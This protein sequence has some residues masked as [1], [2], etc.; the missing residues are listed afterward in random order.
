MNDTTIIK[1]ISN[2]HSAIIDLLIFIFVTLFTIYFTLHI[3]LKLDTFILPGLKIE[4]LYIKWDEKISVKIDSIKITKSNTKNNFDI[5]KVDLKKL[6]RETHVLDTVFSE[7][8]INTIQYNDINATFS[9]KEHHNGYLKIY[10]PRLRAHITIDMNAHLLQFSIK[11]FQD[12]STHSTITGKLLGDTLEHR[13][14]GAL[15][16]NVADTI[17]LDLFLL[18]DR[19]KLSI[20]AKGSQ[21]IT[22]P[23]GPAVE[24]A[25][26]GPLINPWII[27]QLQGES[28]SIDYLKAT[29]E[30]DNPITLLDTLDVKACY[31]GV[32]YVFAPGYAPAIAEK[33][34]LAFKDRIL[35][36]YPRKGTFYGQPGGTT[37]V[38]IDFKTPENPLLTVDVDTT[39]RLSKKLIS[40]LKG[41][42]ITL[43]FY[44]KSG[45]TKVK[46]ALWI[47][48]RDIEISANGGFSSQKGLFNFSDTDIHVKDVKVNL[49]NTDVDIY[50]LNASLLDD[51][52]NVDLSG[53]F[54]PIKEIGRFDI[55]VNHIQFGKPLPFLSADKDFKA[56][57]FSY[58]LQP[59]HDRLIIP[60]SHWRF[61]ERKITIA[62]II[63]PFRFST[64]TGSIPTTHVSSNTDR[65]AYVSG[66]FNIKALSVDLMIDL[67]KFRADALKLDQINAP[68]KVHYDKSLRVDALKPSKW[69]INGT[70]VTLFPSTVSLLQNELTIENGHFQ[71]ADIID[72]HIAGDYNILDGSGKIVLKQL[73]AKIDDR[74]LLNIDKDIKIYL[75]K[76]EQQNIVEVPVFNLKMKSTPK[77][78]QMGIKNIHYISA[79]SPL[80]Q[81]F[82]ITKGSIQIY[83]KEGED[84][85]SLYGYLDYPYQILIKDNKPINTL[86][87]TGTYKDKKLNV[88]V[89]NNLKFLLKYNLLD[90]HSNHIGVNLFS[91]FDFIHDHPVKKHT[92]DDPSKFKVTIEALNSYIYLNEVRRAPADK[93]LLQYRDNDLK[94]QLL[95]GKNGGAALEYNEKKE[96]FIYG[97]RLNDKFMT[98]LAEFSEFK[99]GELSFYLTGKTDNIDGVV[100][101]KDTI[102]KDYKAI[103]NALAFINTI[104][105][106]VTFS[107]PH[108]NTKGLKV[109]EGYA[110]LNYTPGHLLI[111][112]FHINSPEL[113]FNGTGSVDLETKTIDVETSLVTDATKNLSK[114]PLLGYILVGKED[115][116]ITTT[117]TMKG[118]MDNPV[119]KNTLAKDIGIGSFNILKR[120]LT[121]PVHYVETAQK[122]IKEAEKKR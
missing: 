15:K 17:P 45:K 117:L 62:S 64:L 31:K 71:I 21:A 94:A 87:F 105:A 73:E 86:K 108:Y 4:K 42:H 114:I 40:W 122:A 78:W 5:K 98:A 25:H 93:L 53:K 14:Y 110:A 41:Y 1:T 68:F 59:G 44:Q 37:W 7:V 29:M 96:L 49:N 77:E 47:T 32:K 2:V 116:T 75:Q 121:F 61:N 43:P 10:S 38:K 107:V 104:P 39:A 76:K 113:K 9:Y 67:L 28:L 109:T 60:K 72:S 19:E 58:L 6:L 112:G 97:D 70:K 82:N 111:K 56:L 8:T 12:L 85:I 18:A 26:L 74:D 100:K 13:L 101:V 48:L 34:D 22:K 63:A 80:L 69:R 106:L 79:Y 65:Q 46:L 120:A 84:K 51:A 16:V 90:I 91:I 36:I 66:T 20:W 118:P 52:I 92:K 54:N 103:N 102:I 89:N 88:N 95:H 50:S 23:I 119:I 24:I 99:G 30:Y 115:E 35:Y 57:S 27:D 33:V 55:N 3:G 11:E 81:E 83:S